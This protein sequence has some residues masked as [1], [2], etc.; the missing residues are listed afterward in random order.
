MDDSSTECSEGSAATNQMIAVVEEMTD[1]PLFSKIDKVEVKVE[2]K[3]DDKTNTKL[4]RGGM[5]QA[6]EKESLLGRNECS[7][8]RMEEARTN[9]R[10]QNRT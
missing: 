9:A 8:R 5:A 1:T 6:Y 10:K 4:K 7:S 3:K 2:D